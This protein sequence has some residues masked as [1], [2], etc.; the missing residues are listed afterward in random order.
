MSVEMKLPDLGEGVESGT[1]AGILVSVGDEISLEQAVIEMETDKAAFEVPSSVEGVV[2]EIFIAV[3]DEVAVG[4]RILS[5]SEKGGSAGTEGEETRDDAGGGEKDAGKEKDEEGG[6]RTDA[7]RE[8][9]EEAGEAVDDGGVAKDGDGE[10]RER[11]RAQAEAGK[12]DSAEEESTDESGTKDGRTGHG[13]RKETKP[14]ATAGSE[15]PAREKPAKTVPA[16]PSVRRFAREIGVDIAEVTGSGPAGRISI[17]DVKKRSKR[18]HQQRSGGDGGRD[19]RR[20]L[21]DFSKWGSIEIQSMSKIRQTTA[22]HLEQAWAEIPHVTHFDRADITRLEE[23]RSQ[24]KEKA[25]AADAKLTVTSMLVKIAAGALKVFP[26]FNASIDME[27]REIIY[28]RYFNIGVAVD[29]D[30]GLLVP[31]IRDVGCKNIIDIAVELSRLSEK[32]RD[33]SIGIDEMRG[34]CFTIS[35]LGGI[36]GTGFTPVVNWP[37][38]A[39]LGVGRSRMEP[40]YRN[41]A[42][43]AQPMM[44]LALSYDHR[45]IDGADAARFMAWVVEAIENPLLVMLEG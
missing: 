5:V 12:E 24:Y 25:E 43:E 14:D 17:E 23:L 26:R 32:A 34:G 13:V 6:K 15:T 21:P 27:A 1:V 39:I 18:L 29:T 41:G 9:G 28:R 3:G 44:P 30:R 35:N 40:V 16:A 45:L 10:A 37:E 19:S 36:G 38:V 7:D 22:N 42:F 4:G 31:V 2:E 8:P 33:K 20:S 11:K